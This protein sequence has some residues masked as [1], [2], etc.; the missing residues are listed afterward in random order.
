MIFFVQIFKNQKKVW[1]KLWRSDFFLVWIEIFFKNIFSGNF[2]FWKKWDLIF[3]CEL[4][5]TSVFLTNQ[6]CKVTQRC[7]IGIAR[8]RMFP[9]LFFSNSLRRVPVAASQGKTI[10]T[11]FMSRKLS[12]SDS[13]MFCSTCLRTYPWVSEHGLVTSLI[14]KVNRPTRR[15]PYSRAGTGG[16]FMIWFAA[17][18]T[19][20]ISRRLLIEL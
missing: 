20:D 5:C 12:V 15:V 6:S 1:K 3:S 9:S 2:S 4:R 13:W 8:K 19:L 16:S 14:K 18:P 10:L 11:D 7:S 17:S